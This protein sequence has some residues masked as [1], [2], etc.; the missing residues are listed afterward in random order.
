MG[1]FSTPLEWLR[2]EL[3]FG[4]VL[5]AV[6]VAGSWFA[7]R[8]RTRR[9]ANLAIAVRRAPLLGPSRVGRDRFAALAVG[10]AAILGAVALVG[11][12]LGHVERT[13]ERRGVDLVVCL[14][15]SRS[16][17]ARDERPDRLSRAK[18]EVQGLLDRLAGD[19]VALI[20]F[21]GEAQRIAPLTADRRALG[22]LV[23]TAQPDDLAIGGTDLGR[24][25]E[26]A[27]E[28]F[29][30]RSGAH[31]AV[32]L[33]TDGED[34]EGRAA[35]VAERAGRAGIR[36]YVVGVG[37]PEG[38]K[39]PTQDERGRESM[40]RGAD[41]AE[42]ITRLEPATLE[43][44]AEASGG[45]YLSTQTSPTP[46]EELYL[47]R[48]SKL[49]GQGYAGG[50]ERL[51]LDRYQWPLGAAI[52]LLAVGF[53]AQGAR[54]R[55]LPVMLLAFAALHTVAP[56]A[57]A[58]A[59]GS[60]PAASAPAAP[61]L[62][63]SAP[64]PSESSEPSAPFAAAFR[65]ALERA[66]AATPKDTADLEHAFASLLAREPLGEEERALVH[67]SRAA[68]RHGVWR[69]AAEMAVSKHSEGSAPAD[70]AAAIEADLQSAIALAGP[71]ERRYLAIGELGATR[72]ERAERELAHAQ[73][74][75]ALYRAR[76]AGAEPATPESPQVARE[77]VV[78]AYGLARGAYV[79][80]RDP[81]VDLVRGGALDPLA[82]AHLEWTARRVREVD[83]AIE[84]LPPEPPPPEQDPSG[85]GEPQESAGDDKSAGESGDSDK[86]G[87][88]G[89]PD[90]P[91]DP[92]AQSESG[93]GSDEPTGQDPA[94]EPEG[95]DSA[96]EEPT[97]SRE[98]E[99]A[100][101]DSKGGAPEEGA[102]DDGAQPVGT[103]G[104]ETPVLSREEAQRLLDRLA[105][106]EQDAAR[107]RDALARR[108][109][110][111]VAKDW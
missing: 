79:L 31:E 12:G 111:P 10:C 18:R 43:R 67:L 61:A 86:D 41:G 24:A 38:G 13:V 15:V 50:I 60:A 83:A 4:F 35:E 25:L 77:D 6:V 89:E 20:A 47:R 48:I 37:T 5:A 44:L 105:E 65:D 23:E 3:A 8:A 80:A 71:G 72:L 51:P 84:Q 39:I 78:V 94:Q 82:A 103:A 59:Q 109:R 69:G 56:Q 62:A 76:I 96:A 108:R 42:V 14:D 26:L 34:L 58:R 28:L 53:L 11:P 81:L 21:A 55:G 29:D 68:L 101:S 45:E 40:V 9:A 46:L 17:L 85:E 63:A 97:D 99:G 64:A 92:E 16:M 74:A 100:K 2:P 106:I 87:E 102:S 93:D 32:V 88:P 54:R 66:R 110:A 73:A 90:N 30:G 75:R 19:R 52:A 7:I 98:A 27:L 70:F 33:V 22:Q 57:A 1:P 49:E 107:L 36:V 95:E 104:D 91:S